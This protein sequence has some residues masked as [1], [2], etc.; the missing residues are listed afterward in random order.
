M[1]KTGKTGRY[2]PENFY[3]FCVVAAIIEVLIVCITPKIGYSFLNIP[4]IVISTVIIIKL[5][6]DD[7]P[8]AF[9]SSLLINI[10][11]ISL[12]VWVLTLVTSKTI[13][14]N[15][16]IINGYNALV[17][18]V[19]SILT[20][21]FGGSE[22]KVKNGS[23][24]RNEKLKKDELA[25]KIKYLEESIENDKII[26]EIKYDYKEARAGLSSAE[27]DLVD[28]TMNIIIE[29]I[30]FQLDGKVELDEIDWDSEDDFDDFDDSEEYLYAKDKVTFNN[31]IEYSK[32]YLTIINGYKRVKPKEG[33]KSLEKLKDETVEL[34]KK[35]KEINL[36]NKKEEFKYLMDKNIIKINKLI[37]ESRENR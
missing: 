8:I 29:M 24:L 10:Y 20:P 21:V 22:L 35:L 13:D 16:C 2:K 17:C 3:I 26:K 6:D 15:L 9:K 34:Y 25:N 1:S 31:I 19:T 18:I 11:S 28:S 4:L 32:N 30:E 27:K 5:N 23:K 36:N 12:L 37:L 7:Y 14:K 33:I